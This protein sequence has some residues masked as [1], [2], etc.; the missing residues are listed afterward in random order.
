MKKGDFA[1]RFKNYSDSLPYS[2]LF[3]IIYGSCMDKRGEFLQ[4]CLKNFSDHQPFL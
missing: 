4:I 3:F 2:E 1:D